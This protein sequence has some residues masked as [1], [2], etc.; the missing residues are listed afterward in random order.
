MTEYI[1]RIGL[2]LSAFDGFTVEA[3]SDTDAIEKAK[4]AAKATME[5]ATHRECDAGRAHRVVARRHG[6]RVKRAR[7]GPGRV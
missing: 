2:W 3:E 7:G 4:A 1:V 6:G 5:S